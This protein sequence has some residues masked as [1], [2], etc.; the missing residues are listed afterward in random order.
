MQRC[1][2]AINNVPNDVSGTEVDNAQAQSVLANPALPVPPSTHVRPPVQTRTVGH[3]VS[4][5]PVPSGPIK[6]TVSN[7]G[8]GIW[9]STVTGTQLSSSSTGGEKVCKMILKHQIILFSHQ[10]FLQNQSEFNLFYQAISMCKY[11]KVV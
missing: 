7:H 8:N 6:I 9:A 11:T 5:R 4:S 1:T 3:P 10:L 2:N